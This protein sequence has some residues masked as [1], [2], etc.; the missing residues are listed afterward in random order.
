M[1]KS[2]FYAVFLFVMTFVV[3][4]LGT[5]EAQAQN[6]KASYTITNKGTK[7]VSFFEKGQKGLISGVGKTIQSGQ[8]EKVT[9]SEIGH[10]VTVDCGNGKKQTFTVVDK[11]NEF[12]I[13]CN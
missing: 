5:S 7:K 1:K 11:K 3:I 10:T 13:N 8:S 2:M 12:V 9:L 6:K 4:F